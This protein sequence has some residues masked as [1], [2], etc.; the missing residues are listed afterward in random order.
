[1]TTLT[2]R[3]RRLWTALAGAPV[4]FPPAGRIAAVASPASLLCPPGWAGVVVIDGAGIATVPSPAWLDP[5]AA[6]PADL[7]AVRAGLPAAEVLGPAALSYLDRS[8]FRP[9]AGPVEV[10]DVADLS[11]LLQAAGQAD[12]GESG[13]ADIQSPA[14]V[15]RHEG[16]IVAASGYRRWLGTAAHL[17]VLTDARHRG[18][19]LTRVV[20]SAAV[21]HALDR[22]LLPQWR[23]RPA[24]SQRVAAAL[25]FRRLGG[26][27]SLAL[28]A[29]PGP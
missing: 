3:A 10:A 12:A 13:L 17:S 14:F 11:A 28:P 7:D 24:A 9:A 15:H 19:G 6:L 18:R 29:A 8:D 23:A 21:A 26:Q 16:C 20:A 27:V 5:F 1:M 25:G 2:G 4:S 22:G